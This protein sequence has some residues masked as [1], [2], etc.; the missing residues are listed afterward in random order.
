MFSAKWNFFKRVVGKLLNKTKLQTLD[1]QYKGEP[2]VQVVS[3]NQN[4]YTLDLIYKGE[5]FTGTK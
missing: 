5:P 4:S 1:Y 2:F 3:Q